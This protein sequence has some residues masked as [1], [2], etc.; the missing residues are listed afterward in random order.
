MRP[1]RP[2][3]PLLPLLVARNRIDHPQILDGD[4]EER[5]VELEEDKTLMRDVASQSIVLL[6]NEGSLLPLQAKALKKVAIV[7]GNAK[8]VV[9]S[10]GGSAALKPSYFISP[11]AGIAEAL[12]KDGVEVTFSEGARGKKA[13][14]PTETQR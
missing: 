13:N 12:A 4:G 14:R 3:G 1:R 8:A 2:R 11:Y 7:G 10:G 5:T 6:K 9:L